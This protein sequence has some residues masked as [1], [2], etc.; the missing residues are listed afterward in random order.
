MRIRQAGDKICFELDNQLQ[1]IALIG[2]LYMGEFEMGTPTP[3]MVLVYDMDI[4]EA[5]QMLCELRA[6][7]CGEC[8]SEQ[9]R[10][11]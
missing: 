11:F 2:L 5:D 10:L 4:S 8:D 1:F 3:T 6:A 9:S 7:L